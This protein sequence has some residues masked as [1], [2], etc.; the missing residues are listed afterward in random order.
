MGRRW[1]DGWRLGLFCPRPSERQRSYHCNPHTYHILQAYFLFVVSSYGI[2]QRT[3]HEKYD[4]LNDSTKPLTDDIPMADRGD[5]WDFRTSHELD[6]ARG[7]GQTGKDSPSSTIDAVP[8]RKETQD[9]YDTY[10][11]R[12]PEPQYTD[13]HVTSRPHLGGY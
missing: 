13:N 4:V 6:E 5:P 10:P 8:P 2:S 11:S 3:D 7:R 9:G 1:C 12:V